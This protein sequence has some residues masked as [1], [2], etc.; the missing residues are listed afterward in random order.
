MVGIDLLIAKPFRLGITGHRPDKLGG[1]NDYENLRGLLMLKMRDFFLEKGV[2]TLV[3][4]MALGTDQWATETALDLGIRV[5]AMIPCLNQEKLWPAISQAYY[6]ALLDRIRKAE[7][8]IIYVSLQNYEK[9]CMHRRN[10]EIVNSSEE[11]LAVWT[12]SKGGTKDCVRVAIRAGLP[13]TVLN[14]NTME[15]E[16]HEVNLHHRLL[17]ESDGSEDR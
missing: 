7:G 10:L 1:Y 3:S 8:H 9:G 15:F 2:T 13:V 12:G 14:P 11:M 16:K 6:H 5:A 4:G 17:A